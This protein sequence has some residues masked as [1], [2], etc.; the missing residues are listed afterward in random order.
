MEWGSD[1][2]LSKKSGLNYQSWTDSYTP[3]TVNLLI[4]GVVWIVMAALA[5]PLGDFPLNDDWVYGLAVKSVLETGYYQFPSPSSANVGP[6]VYWGAL[7]CL[8]FGF[9]F[10]ALRF[11]SLAL[12]L[13]GVLALYGLIRALG[14]KPQIALLG[15]LTLSVNPLY[16]G[17]AHSFMTDVPFISLVMLALFFLVRGFQRDSRFY[18][19]IGLVFAFAAILVRQ[20]GLIVL[21]AFAFAYP[22][23]NGF[24]FANIAKV[25][26]L[27][28][29]GAL[30]H[31]AYQYWLVNTGRT[32][33]LSVHSDIH[34]LRLP[35]LPI[36][37]KQLIVTFIYV[38]FFVLPFVAA[39]S[40]SQPKGITYERLK[41]IWIGVFALAISILGVFWWKAGVMPLGE[42]IL[43]ESGLG[44][45]TLRDTYNLKLNFPIIS[46]SVAIFWRGITV[47]SALAACAALYYV[48][49]ASHQAYIGFKQSR[50]STWQYPL[51]AVTGTAYLAILLAVSG[52]FTLFDRYLLLFLPIVV[53]IIAAVKFEKQPQVRA[54][55][56]VFSISLLI[57]YAGFSV[58]ATHDYLAWNRTRWIA[59]HDLMDKQKVQPNQIDGG[60]EFNGWFLYD[61]KYKKDPKKSW[62]WVDDDE[63]AITSGPLPG[64]S[65]MQ[66]YP[67]RRWLLQ[68]EFN[69]YVLR[70]NPKN[71]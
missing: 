9:S 58:A 51:F 14:G 60:Y 26:T 63:Y 71:E 39:F 48:G 52:R 12:G 44:P 46:P 69:I 41:N 28:I 45:L 24:R 54:T 13:I 33:L 17:L 35:S 3:D 29:A 50:S 53:L 32:P 47:L 22:I 37:S 40:L 30:L 70:K 18:L 1:I 55:R 65:E 42:N 38:G 43:V 23:K 62:W 25:I 21:L 49:I 59:L 11:S 5:N 67:F 20:L 68:S 34:T 31:I 16:F 64:Y 66:R 10:T 57:L 61:A 8:P 6:Q 36:V 27:V 2:L 15:A 19:A 7:F 4:I 56:V